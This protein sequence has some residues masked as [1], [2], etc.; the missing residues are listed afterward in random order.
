MK[1][2]KVSVA[3]FQRRHFNITK[4]IKDQTAHWVNPSNKIVFTF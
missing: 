3:T 2:R 1:T 4:E